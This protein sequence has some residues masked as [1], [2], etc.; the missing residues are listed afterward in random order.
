[1]RR[2]ELGNLKIPEHF[3]KYIAIS[4]GTLGVNFQIVAPE[5]DGKKLENELKRLEKEHAIRYF[6]NE[7]SAFI[8]ALR[9]GPGLCDIINLTVEKDESRVPVIY[10][11]SGQLRLVT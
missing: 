11:I 6:A 5:E 9:S 1:L 7:D 2:L 3:L 10:R 4:T 8:G